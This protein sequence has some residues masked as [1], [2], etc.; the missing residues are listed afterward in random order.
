[1]MNLD[2]IFSLEVNGRCLKFVEPEEVMEITIGAIWELDEE[3]DIDCYYEMG[4]RIKLQ[5]LK[6]PWDSLDHPDG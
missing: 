1:M 2:F 3:G 5:E 4:V 6:D